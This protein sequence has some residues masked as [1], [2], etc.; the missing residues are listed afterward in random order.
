VWLN[1]GHRPID[2]RSR[3]NCSEGKGRHH[4]SICLTV[5]NQSPLSESITKEAQTSLSIPPLN[6][7]ATSCVG[8]VQRA[9][10]KVAL[11]TALAKVDGKLGSKV[12]VLV[13]TGSHKS[14]ITNKAVNSLEL[15]PVKEETLG[16]KVLGKTEVDV[17]L[18]DVVDLSLTSLTGEKSV[19][20]E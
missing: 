16:I 8:N 15:R 1:S 19:R 2:C 5:P 13:D 3:S 7:Q 20:I 4:V 12:R 9:K 17:K 10:E 14:F 11:Q 6:P 18:K